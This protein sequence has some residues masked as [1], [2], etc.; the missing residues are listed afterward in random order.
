V[1]RSAP[2]FLLI[3]CLAGIFLA[4][5]SRRPGPLAGVDRAFFD[6]LNA[7]TRLPPASAAGIHSTVTLVEIDDSIADAPGRL[8]L[9]PLEYASF[10]Q[11]AGKYDPAVVA[12]EPILEWAKLPAGTEEILAD[13]ALILPKLLLG[14]ELG[15]NPEHP[16]D[17]ASLPALGRVS[18][19]PSALPE[20]PEIVAAPSARLLSLAAASGAINLP[21]LA[22]APVRDLPLLLRSRDR[23]LPS[24][25]LQILMLWLR[26]AP[27]EVS[28]ELGS[29]VQLGDVLRLPIN[30]HGRALLDQREFRSFSRLNLD[31]LALLAANEA[32]PETKAAAE[33]MRG[34]I[35]ILG[36]T[37][38]AAR[39]LR[40]VGGG[41]VS[42]AEVFAWSAVSLARAP[43]TRRAGAEWDAAVVLI[44][45]L[46]AWR[47]GQTHR[48]WAALA[49]FGMFAVYGLAAL[50]CFA[51]ERLWLP[52]SLPVGL[53]LLVAV[54]LWVA[55]HK[56]VGHD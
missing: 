23:V 9:A 33:R 45:M 6:W 7:N 51:M 46:A 18:G 34:G 42:P 27:S 3:V 39:T 43:S 13:Q 44:W 14:V 20:F 40:L 48:V 35:V 49:I 8:P 55:P 54:L 26:L 19:D 1:T 41:E 10:L 15:S 29:H 47:L 50:S 32:A 38:H 25:G 17:P 21:G 5:E 53:G 56:R 11:V 12:I 36:R 52:A 2:W 22:G 28:V 37:D 24:F 16:R 31:D 30:R 4:R